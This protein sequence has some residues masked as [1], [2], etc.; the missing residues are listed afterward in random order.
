MRKPKLTALLVAILMVAALVPVVRVKAADLATTSMYFNHNTAGLT[1]GVEADLYFTT[2]TAVSGGSGNNKVIIAFATG[3][4]CNASQNL[5]TGAP[6]AKETA[7]TLPG[8]LTATCNASGNQITITG[9]DDL[10]ASTKYGV[11]L[12]GNNLYTASAGQH[13]TTVTTNN[14]SADVD[15]RHIALRTIS[16]DDI[17][18][19]GYIGPTLT[20]D[21]RDTDMNNNIGFGTITADAVRYATADGTGSATL[22]GAS[23]PVRIYGSTNADDGMAIYYRGTGDGSNSG[24]YNSAAG[25]L[26]ISD[27]QASIVAGTEGYAVWGN[28]ASGDFTVDA[29]TSAVMTL[30]DQLFAHSSAPHTTATVDMDAE[31]AISPTTDAGNYADTVHFTGTGKF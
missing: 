9:V 13:D 10:S 20:F 24:M 23:E 26:I 21:V 7:T 6:S 31:I 12:S 1:S 28:N 14:G 25:K 17:N 27:D 2:T 11:K 19:T 30:S 5:T 16:D 4:W 29:G 18:I 22:P 3:T 8:T 15:S